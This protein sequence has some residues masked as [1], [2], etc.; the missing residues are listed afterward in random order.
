MSVNFTHLHVHTQYSLLDGAAKI[1]DLVAYAKEI[2]MKSLAITDHGVMY[3]VVDFYQ[4]AMKQGIKPVIGC[5]VYL[6]NGSRFE[7]T[8]RDGMYHLIL[9]AENDEGYHNLMKLVSLGHLEGFYYKPRIDK[10]ILRQYSK[11]IICMSACIAGEI[12]VQIL[13]GNLEGAENS[14]KDYLDI[15]GKDNFFLEIQDHDLEEEHTVNTELKRLAKKYDLGLVATNDSHY[16]KREDADAQ[17]VLLCIQTTSTVDDPKRM[18]FP[19]D[20]FYLKSEAEMREKFGDCPEALENTAK[21]AERCN[22]ELSF[23]HLLL[24]EFPIPN[25]LSAEEYLRKLCLDGMPGRYPEPTQQVL[26]RL[27]YELGIINKMGYDCYFLIVWDFIS[28]S[29]RNDIPV[30]P[31]RG[32]AAGSIVAYLLGI[33]NI[34]PLK[35]DLLFERFL[36]PER[37]SMPDIDTDFCYEK[38]QQVLD[39]IINRYGQEKVAQIITFGTLQARAAV[40]DVGRAL[41]MPYSMVDNVAKLI[42]RDLGIT[43]ERALEASNELRSLYENDANIKRLI[44]LAQSVEGMPRNSGTHAA[45]VVI[46]P[47]DL[48][49]YVPLQLSNENFITTEYDKDKIESLGLLKMDLLG[50]RTLT[51]IGDAIKF[52]YETTGDKLDI[53]KIPLDDEATCSML[54]KGDTQGV[55]QLESGG[56]TKLVMDLGPESFE[57]LIPLVALYRPGPLGTG[58]VEDFIAG[59]HGEKTA[60][61]LHPLLEPVLKDT[62]GVI[63]YQEQ[64]MQ[65]TSVLAGFSLGQADIL[66]R[67]MGKKKAKELDSMREAF[68]DGAQQKHGISPQLSSEIFALLQHFAGYGFNKSHSAAYALVAYQTAY[69]KAHWPAEFMA[70]FLTSVISDSEKLSWYISVCR[71]MGLKILPPDVNESGR[72]FSVN[73]DRVIRF[74]LA[75]VK[76]VGENAIGSILQ[77]RKEG[78]FKSLMDFCKR[79]DNRAVN[80]RML[81]NL[82][83]CGAMDSFGYKRSELLAVA[84]QAMDMGSNYQKDYQ[85]GQMGLFGDD[86]FADVN[87][88]RIPELEEIPKRM[89]LQYEKELI[90]FY[91]TGNPLDAYVGS[92]YYY[93]PL[94]KIS[95]AS[96]V[97]DG[98]YFSV[99]GIISDCRIRNTRQ[100]DSMAILTLEDFNGKMEIVVFPKVYRDAARLLY[101][102]NAIS[103]EGKLSIDERERKIQALKIKPLQEVPPDLH[104]KIM[105]K[106][107]NGIVQKGLKQIFESFSGDTPVY[108]HLID[109]GK[110][111]KVERCFW[112]DGKNAGV[113]QA[114][115]DL[116]G[117]NWYLKG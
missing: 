58:M 17:D 31:G 99:A 26:D 57:D 4:E 64:V 113:Y 72:S 40:R 37:V 8:N 83:K 110:M 54:R 102:E 11:G 49:K 9:L 25:G 21:I 46:A 71:S 75:G 107:E 23:G 85:S 100:G 24:P 43:L 90:G 73:K 48:K 14:L 51:V 61:M 70:A 111:I 56:M 2:G 59:R 12:P 15:F 16:V 95:D 105:K 6:T 47:D 1:S 39:Y 13:R 88:L 109:S 89:I 27:E 7:K 29:R 45:G 106:D 79:V 22:V 81:E 18:K 65:I 98:K 20:Q 112:V 32:S 28:Y 103:V 74:G 52:I 93:T 55:F 60:E 33:T 62:F 50:L 84:E 38:R 35:Y 86:S 10:D 82:I 69:L 78:P 44:D 97:L 108:L 36:N 87:E 63:L 34:D 67:A 41:E 77:A 114:L 76:N 5:E 94:R 42:P 104:I 117:E 3:G 91:V 80:K 96:E 68:I 101:Q 115:D 30:G 66:R 116:L 19:N 92:L 53:D